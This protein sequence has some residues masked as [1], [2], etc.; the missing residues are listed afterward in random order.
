MFHKE[1]ILQLEN[2]VEKQNTHQSSH[3]EFSQHVAE[4]PFRDSHRRVNHV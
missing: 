3:F 1:I 4:Q 2:E